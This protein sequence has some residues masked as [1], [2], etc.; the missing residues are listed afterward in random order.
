M[1]VK[2][3]HVKKL[4]RNWH[5]I[6][7]VRRWRIFDGHPYFVAV[8]SKKIVSTKNKATISEAIYLLPMDFTLKHITNKNSKNTIVDLNKN[9]TLC[10]SVSPFCTASSDRDFGKCKVVD[11]CWAWPS[12][13]A[14][15][16]K[17]LLRSHGPWSRVR[18][19][20]RQS[21]EIRIYYCWELGG[22][23]WTA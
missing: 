2:C 5:E 17:Q 6:L 4:L 22:P 15:N 19:T 13:T 21:K 10:S 12:L 11:F 9:S 7:H 18:K 23:P 1:V 3:M 16:P 20:G 8:E 14:R